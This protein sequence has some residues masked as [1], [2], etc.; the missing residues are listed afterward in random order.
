ML[1]ENGA[2]VDMADMACIY[3][4]NSSII[5]IF[6]MNAWLLVVIINTTLTIKCMST[7]VF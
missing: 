6:M 5:V 1:I 7:F 2:A 3:A 4:N